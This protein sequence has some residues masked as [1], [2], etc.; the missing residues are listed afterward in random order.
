MI[1]YVWSDCQ[2]YRSVTHYSYLVNTDKPNVQWSPKFD[3]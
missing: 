1:I 3:Q 2:Y